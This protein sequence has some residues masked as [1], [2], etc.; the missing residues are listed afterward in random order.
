MMVVSIL[1]HLIV[2]AERLLA[3]CGLNKI[4]VVHVTTNSNCGIRNLTCVRSGDN[5]TD[6]I[7]SANEGI[8][9]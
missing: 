5:A 6:E 7:P 4:A 2:I 1:Q 3:V 9:Q 8:V